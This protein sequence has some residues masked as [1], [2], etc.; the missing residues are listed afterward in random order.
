VTFQAFSDGYTAIRA[1]NTESHFIYVS[2]D[3]PAR[4]FGTAFKLKRLEFCYDL[5]N[6][7][8]FITEVDA[9]Y[10]DGTGVGQVLISDLTNRLSTYWSC[11]GIT[12]ATPALIDGSLI[13]RFVLNFDNTKNVINIGKIKLILTQQ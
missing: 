13:V 8:N 5:D 2:A 6:A 3:V 4:L 11:V 9:R 7:T 1:S 12:D 10:V